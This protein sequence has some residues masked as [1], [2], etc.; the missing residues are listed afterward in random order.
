MRTETP[1]PIH[2]KDYQPSP[3][4][5]DGVDLDIRPDPV[6]T[7]V[8]SRLAMR[9]NPKSA[10]PGGPIVLDGEA[11]TFESA[12]LEGQPLAPEQISFENG[13]LTLSDI[14]AR[15]VTIEISSSCNPCL[16]PTF[17]LCRFS[18]SFTG[19]PRAAPSR[20]AVLRAGSEGDV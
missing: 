5:I 15:A 18:T 12:S 17:T 1:Q 20:P 4:L 3:W 8:V 16:S 9:P 19:M 2:L 14:P 11:L 7:R 6:E 10:E 13:K